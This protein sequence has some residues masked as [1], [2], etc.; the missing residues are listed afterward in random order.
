MTRALFILLI[1]VAT[2]GCTDANVSVVKNHVAPDGSMTIGKALDDRNECK[3]ITW[4]PVKTPQNEA[5]VEYTCTYDLSKIA[6]VR[7]ELSKKQV[8]GLV[9][10]ENSAYQRAREQ[11][12]RT[13][14]SVKGTGAPNAAVLEEA[15]KQ[16][17]DALQANKDRI[18]ALK[19]MSPDDFGREVMRANYKPG[20]RELMTKRL[21]EEI[22]LT[23]ERQAILESDGIARIAAKQKELNG[24]SAIYSE[25]NTRFEQNLSYI[26]AIKADYFAELSALEKAANEFV[27]AEVL[28]DGAIVKQRFTFALSQQG[29]VVQVQN[30]VLFNDTEAPFL[31]SDRKAAGAAYKQ[32]GYEMA[33]EDWIRYVASSKRI[34]TQHIF[35]EFSYVCHPGNGLCKKRE[36]KPLGAN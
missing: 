35:K 27:D 34:G 24:K 23:Q 6:P 12:I 28:K 30:R 13:L 36:A 29:R 33:P 2:G 22:A 16:H 4:E 26:D 31:D 15:T 18:V 1:A 7:R 25:Q 9:E 8:V 19:K 3:E 10:I 11:A 20:Y 17:Q 32:K 5:M 21:A 14:E